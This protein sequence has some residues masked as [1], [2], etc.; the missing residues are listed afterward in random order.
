MPGPTLLGEL[1]C[2]EPDEQL[3]NCC[4]D[5][6]NEPPEG[7][8][9]NFRMREQNDMPRWLDTRKDFLYDYDDDDPHSEEDEGGSGD[10][11]GL[12]EPVLSPGL[13]KILSLPPR[14]YTRG[15]QVAV[16]KELVA[17]GSCS[18]LRMSVRA[19]YKR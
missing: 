10:D 6:M 9:F 7:D 19:R 16:D 17:A 1:D 5:D 2:W 15:M 13:R 8:D 4:P 12:G 18:R 3:L 11:S 14:D